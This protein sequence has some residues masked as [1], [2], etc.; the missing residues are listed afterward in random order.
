[1][2]F[3]LLLSSCNA[4][5]QYTTIFSRVKAK[6]NNRPLSRFM[7]TTLLNVENSCNIYINISIVGGGLEYLSVDEMAH[8]SICLELMV[9]RIFDYLKID[10]LFNL[11]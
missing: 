5:E 1:M 11:S 6:L 9:E 2:C 3:K 7:N 10:L 8:K 4:C